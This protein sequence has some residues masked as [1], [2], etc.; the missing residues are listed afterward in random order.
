M[1][2]APDCTMAINPSTPAVRIAR[3]LGEGTRIL[4][5]HPGQPGI[6]VTYD[7]TALLEAAQENCEES[8]PNEQTE[9]AMA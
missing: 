2:T 6:D 8:E 7:I 3:L 9:A 4:A 1:I 5:V